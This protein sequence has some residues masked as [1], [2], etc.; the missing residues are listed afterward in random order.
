MPR[1]NEKA[2]PEAREK[3]RRSNPFSCV[4]QTPN[5]LYRSIHEAAAALGIPTATI[6][7]YVKCGEEQRRTGK[8]S[9]HGND[10][11]EWKKLTAGVKPAAKPCVTPVGE[12]PSILAAAKAYK[13][14][15]NVM[16]KWLNVGKSG[17][18][19]KEEK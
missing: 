13:V 3:A 6:N 7:Y 4:V 12:F 10:F 1:K 2:T 15:N 18:Y 16:L 19:Y 14:A 9:T 17:F 8:L 11:R 5:G